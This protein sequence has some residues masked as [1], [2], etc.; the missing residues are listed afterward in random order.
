VDKDFLTIGRLGAPKGVRGDLKLQSYSGEYEHFRKLK[1]LEL[2]SPAD[3]PTAAVPRKLKLKVARIDDA[4]GSPTIAFEGYPS[5][6][7]ARELTGLEIIA[8]RSG[9]A[10]LKPNEWY[11]TDLVGLSLVAAHGSPDEGKVYGQVRSVLEGGS[12]PWL[13]I[14]RTPGSSMGSGSSEGTAKRSASDA[15]LVPFRK[16]FVGEVDLAA[17]T[18]ELLAPY[19][20]DE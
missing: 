10:P 12:D 4:S 17:G 15:S 20:L 14:V 5:P 19:L 13:E 9:A 1:E 16:E 6:E 3:A 18:I 2:R 11:V 7:K 8:P